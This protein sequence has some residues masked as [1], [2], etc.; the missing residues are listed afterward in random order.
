MDEVHNLDIETERELRKFLDKYKGTSKEFFS[1]KKS[2]SV[3]FLIIDRDEVVINARNIDKSEKD[4]PIE[5]SITLLLNGILRHP[6]DFDK[7]T[8]YAEFVEESKISRMNSRS[9]DTLDS[10]FYFTL[11]NAFLE[12][13]P[14][15]INQICR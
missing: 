15:D 6:F 5:L 4:K 1:G 12:E 11:H 8:D 2:D 3:P 14:L 13:N 9:K 10:K 7:V